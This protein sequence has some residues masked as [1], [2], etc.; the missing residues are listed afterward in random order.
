MREL[1]HVED[2][3]SQGGAHGL[4]T[5]EEEVTERVVEINLV[6]GTARFVVQAFLLPSIYLVEVPVYQ[7]SI[8]SRFLGIFVILDHPVHEVLHRLLD[9]VDL[10]QLREGQPPEDGEVVD[11]GGVGPYLGESINRLDELTETGIVVLESLAEVDAADDVRYRGFHDVV[12]VERF[13]GG[14]TERIEHV[15]DLLLDVTL[16]TLFAESEVTESL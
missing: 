7:V 5:S 1:D 2:G 14:G 16:E 15:G 8:Y 6:K 11:G 3:P 10:L 13:T 9:F 12:R 4:C